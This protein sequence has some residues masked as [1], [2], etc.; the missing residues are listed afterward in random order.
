[1]KEKNERVNDFVL[2]MREKY[3]TQLDALE[4]KGSTSEQE[5]FDKLLDFSMELMNTVDVP[6]TTENFT[7]TLIVL[8]T[9]KKEK[10]SKDLN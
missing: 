5:K 9:I 8:E 1:M 10:E 7:K 6:L 3:K 4:A 2:R